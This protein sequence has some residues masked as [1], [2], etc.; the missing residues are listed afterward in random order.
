MVTPPALL[1]LLSIIFT[2][3]GILPFQMNLRVAFSMSLKNCVGI[4]MGIALNLQIACVM[5]FA[6]RPF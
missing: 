3:L 4:L 2:R 1:L 5:H 6:F